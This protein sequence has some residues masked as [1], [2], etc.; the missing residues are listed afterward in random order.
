MKIFK[1][2]FKVAEGCIQGIGFRELVEKIAKEENK[3]GTIK[4]RKKEE[5]CEIQAAFESEEKFKEFLE[6]IIKTAKKELGPDIQYSEIFSSDKPE[7]FFQ[8]QF[9]VIKEDDL[10]ETL[11]DLNGAKRGF[12]RLAENVK[13]AEKR[14]NERLLNG[15]EQ[16][17]KKLNGQFEDCQNRNKEAIHWPAISNFLAEPFDDDLNTTLNELDQAMDGITQKNTKPTEEEINQV[18]DLTRTA[19]KRIKTLQGKSS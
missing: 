1:T 5:D 6:K 14:R 11:W 19:T 9:Q 13:D 16:E 10:K 3:K 17:L 2:S 15:L 18:K 12:N 7:E 8:N 4:N